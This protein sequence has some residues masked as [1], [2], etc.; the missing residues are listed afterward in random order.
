MG[1]TIHYRGSLAD[2]SRVEDFEDR[3][4][5][6]ALALG[7]NPRLWRSA[8]KDTPER[9]VRGLFLDLAP[10]QETTSLLISPEGWLI[11]L[12]DIEDAE[13]GTL[14]ERPWCFVK[15]QY[16]PIEGHV[17]VVEL[18]TALK[19]EFMPDLEVMDEGG[20][21]EHRDLAELKR[22]T[23]FLGKAIHMLGDA[24]A[25]DRLS[26]EAAED[27]EILAT[28]IERLAQQVH[29]TLSR[30]AEHPPVQFPDETGAPPSP[31]ENE[32]SWDAMFAH[33]RRNQERMHRVIEE[34]TLRG[35]DPGDAFEAAI[36]EVIAPMDW[37]ED[38]EDISEG[39]REVLELIE[40]LDEASQAAAEETWQP[41]DEAE[42]GNE[43]ERMERHPLQQQAT[44]LLME[45]YDLSKRAEKRPG[46]I[47]TLLVNAMEI[48]GG[49]AQVL[50]LSPTYEMD[51]NEAGLAFV[52]LKRALRGA[53]FVHGTLFLL[54]AEKTVTDEEFR[55]FLAESKSISKQIND[56]LRSIRERQA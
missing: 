17:A 14:D 3:V 21:W 47:D 37:A 11:G 49:L 5:D 23:E 28:R 43:F 39:R 45:F 25:G 1:I 2:L 7:G 41:E 42:D 10:G 38:D 32:A 56:L 16:G 13:R 24:I 51:D 34:R 4:I 15:T 6:L 26:S 52:Q 27:P 30:P 12:V 55:R 29:Q 36:E 44:R 54:H 19:R 53:A 20:Y 33:N 35:E 48:T 46:N 50:P 18:L 22:K 9:M 31:E 8:D 40:E